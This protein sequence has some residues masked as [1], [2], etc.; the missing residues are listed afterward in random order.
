M[1]APALDTSPADEA[2]KSALDRLVPLRG[3][4]QKVGSGY[5]RFVSMMKVGLPVM[6]LL[7]VVLVLIWPSLQSGN[8]S[9]QLTFASIGEDAD[10]ITGMSNARFVGTDAANRPYVITAATASQSNASA[11]TI[12]LNMLQADMTLGSGTWVTMTA[13]K[14]VYFRI[15]NR[16]ELIG[17]VDVFSDLGYEFHAGDTTV[18]LAAN[19]ATSN[20]AVNGQGPFGL[21]SANSFRFSDKGNNLIFDGDV[22]L[23]IEPLRQ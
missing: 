21:L 16:L 6:A 18:D 17:P 2:R 12:T 20:Q 14:G 3:T 10:G 7:L 5:S 1:I 15:D 8:E 13:D 4:I 9:F 22:K 23:N 11:D 19:R